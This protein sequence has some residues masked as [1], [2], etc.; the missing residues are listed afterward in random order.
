M[1]FFLIHFLGQKLGDQNFEVKYKN[2]GKYLR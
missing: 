1:F 2:L